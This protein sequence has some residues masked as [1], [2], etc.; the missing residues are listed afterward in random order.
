MS[1]SC[2]TTNKAIDAVKVVFALWLHLIKD[3]HSVQRTTVSDVLSCSIACVQAVVVN[4]G[5]RFFEIRLAI[6]ENFILT[7]TKLLIAS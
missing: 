1:A 6:I 3:S 2:F 7:T 4:W 5:D